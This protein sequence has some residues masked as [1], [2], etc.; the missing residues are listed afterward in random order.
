MEVPGLGSNQS[1]SCRPVPQPQ[2]HRIW[3]TSSRTLLGSQPTE[4]Q[5]ELC[6]LHFHIQE[7]HLLDIFCLTRTQKIYVPN[8][9]T[10]RYAQVSMFIRFF[11]E[12]LYFLYQFFKHMDYILMNCIRKNPTS[13]FSYIYSPNTIS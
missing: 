2:P 5:Q 12:D 9:C 1:V 8:T 11:E 13:S 7:L 6:I 10:H 4:S 3:A